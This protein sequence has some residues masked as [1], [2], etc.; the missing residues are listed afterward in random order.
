[1]PGTLQSVKRQQDG[2]SLR[3]FARGT[4]QFR[5]RSAAARRREQ[6]GVD[7]AAG[8]AV[9]SEVTVQPV[10]PIESRVALPFQVVLVVA[11]RRPSSAIS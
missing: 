6:S 3:R 10:D 2:R 1:M 4:G 5:D 8:E 11:A 9:E 7:L